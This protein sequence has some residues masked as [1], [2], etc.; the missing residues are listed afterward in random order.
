MN[1]SLLEVR[2]VT[3]SFGGIRAVDALS[4]DAERGKIT[5]LIG[6]NGAGKTTVFNLIT[7]VYRP[8]SGS[9]R[10]EG[11]DLTRKRPD[12]IVRCGVA[13]TFQNIRLFKR[14]SCLENVMTPLLARVACG[15]L[16]ALF[17][18]PSVR[19]EK[20]AVQEKAYSIMEAL[21]IADV[22]DR[23][24]FTL[25]YGQ[26][27]KL[28]VARALACAPKLLLLDEPAAGMNDA[29]TEELAGTIEKVRRNF[30]VTIIL[31]EHHISLV[32]SICTYI[33]VMDRGALLA[34]GTPRE[35]R[36]DERVVEAYLGRRRTGGKRS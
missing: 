5:G 4:F 3:R 14:M 10:F 28:E 15:P 25:P 12:E 36:E 31:I 29:E 16:R 35:V 19:N 20:R 32:M 23:N 17:C 1:D 11:V 13:R 2:D 18:G 9:I 33:V 34:S 30:D 6:P 24:A 26:Q 21:D 27:R 8:T 22:A 7:A